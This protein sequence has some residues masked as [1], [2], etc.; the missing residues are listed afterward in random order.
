[1][2]ITIQN[3]KKLQFEDIKA[4]EVFE[5]DTTIYLKT[6]K[7][8][9][10]ANAVELE[11]GIWTQFFPDDEVKKLDVELIIKGVID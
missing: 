4:G 5:Y 9:N 3:D 11:T 1:M 7:S 6:E 2:K 8:S 10:D